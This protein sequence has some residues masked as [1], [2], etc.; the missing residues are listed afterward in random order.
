LSLKNVQRV[1][2]LGFQIPEL[3]M[4]QNDLK[5]VA[6]AAELAPVAADLG[7]KLPFEV[8]FTRRAEIEVDEAEL[9][10]L[11]VEG[12]GIDRLPELIRRERKGCRHGGLLVDLARAA[13]RR[14]VSPFGRHPSTPRFTAR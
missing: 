2:F 10:A 1:L 4:F 6:D 11:L 7:E 13:Q 12:H 5:R 14:A 8:G 9:S 3:H